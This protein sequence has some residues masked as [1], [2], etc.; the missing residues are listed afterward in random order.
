MRALMAAALASMAMVGTSGAAVALVNTPEVAGTCSKYV[1]LA[2]RGS[3]QN[4]PENLVPTR[5]T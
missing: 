1:V 4:E 3:D 2:A 5:Y